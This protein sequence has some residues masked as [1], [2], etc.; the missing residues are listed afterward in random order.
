MMYSDLI[1][2]PFKYGG[3]DSSGLDCWGLVCEMLERT[4]Q[5]PPNYISSSNKQVINQLINDSLENDAWVECEVGTEN[6]VMLFR[7]GRLTT[8]CAFTL[9]HKKFIHAW[10][11]SGGVC[12]ERFNDTWNKR[13]V[14]CY[15]YVR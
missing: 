6:S 7:M 1:G 11:K 13:L 12:V 15:K 5:N 9:P 4:H 14:G 10:E 2:I 8:H 3:R